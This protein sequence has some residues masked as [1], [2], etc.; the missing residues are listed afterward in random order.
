MKS[1]EKWLANYDALKTYIEEHHHLPDKHR[2]ENRGLLSWAL[3]CTPH[4][5]KY[6]T[7][8]LLKW[9]NLLRGQPCEH[10]CFS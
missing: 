4:N 2:V 3:C 7:G 9:W 5:V 1:D 6:R 10:L 8:Y